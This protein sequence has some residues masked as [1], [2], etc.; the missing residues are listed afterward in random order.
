MN[1]DA[2]RIAAQLELVAVTGCRRRNWRLSHHLKHQYNH[3]PH[4]NLRLPKKIRSFKLRIKTGLFSKFQ[5]LTFLRPRTNTHK[6]KKKEEA[7]KQ[8]DSS[9]INGREHSDMNIFVVVKREDGGNF[10]R[11]HYK[12]L[13]HC[14]YFLDVDILTSP[15]LTRHYSCLFFILA[16]AHTAGKIWLPKIVYLW[17]SSWSEQGRL[18]ELFSVGTAV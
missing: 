6:C 5:N 3:C 1:P 15:H 7:N 9:L 4:Q 12:K 10:I 14:L 16:Q 17:A 2:E 8:G 11:L 18:L 13:A